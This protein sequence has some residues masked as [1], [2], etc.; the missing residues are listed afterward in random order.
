[1]TGAVNAFF[2]GKG[3]ASD[4]TPNAVNWGNVSGTDFAANAN[5]TISGITSSITISLSISGNDDSETIS[6][7]IDSGSYVGYT[8]PFSVSNGQTLN[9][10][11]AVLPLTTAGGTVTVRNDSAGSVTLDTFTYSVGSS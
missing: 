10:G 1:M 7:R 5:Q 8:I 11:V 4:V 6:Y 9:F 3:G 2:G